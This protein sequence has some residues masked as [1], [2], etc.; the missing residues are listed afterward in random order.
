MLDSFLMN[1]TYLGKFPKETIEMMLTELKAISGKTPG[2]IAA[3]NMALMRS[4]LSVAE[5][6][7]VG[8]EV[9]EVLVRNET[10]F[11]KALGSYRKVVL[12]DG[13]Q[14]NLSK[15]LENLSVC[16]E[17]GILMVD[18]YADLGDRTGLFSEE[19]FDG[20]QLVLKGFRH[21]TIQG[22]QN[23]KIVVDPRYA[24]L[25]RFID[26][27][28]LTFDNLTLGHTEGGYC[29]G[30]VLGLES[31]S[32]VNIYRCDMYGCG[33]YGIEA[34][35]CNNVYMWASIIRDCSYG[36]LVLNA[37][38]GFNSE[39]CD[40]YRN[41][42]FELIIANSACSDI[43]FY[44]CRFSQNQGVLFDLHIDIRLEDCEVH[45]DLTKLGSMS[46]VS[47]ANTTWDGKNIA[48]PARQ[49]GPDSGKEV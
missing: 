22:G 8:N 45:H 3:T 27:E 19:V 35:H 28:E 37:C 41:Q 21:L 5:G 18:A 36:I 26:C 42:K 11:L 38:N 17:A 6:R 40:F 48:L 10:E 34:S 33:T 20:R 32:E 16:N 15:A 14:L 7:R 23:C 9:K 44:N 24:Y 30:G 43:Q 29:E 25:F 13:L 46:E 1:T 49:I 47:D 39:N 31:C 12:E 2:I 4:E